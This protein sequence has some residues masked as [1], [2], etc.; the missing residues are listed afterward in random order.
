MADRTA[1][2]NVLGRQGPAAGTPDRG[3]RRPLEA[4]GT[5]R[6]RQQG[7]TGRSRCAATG[8]VPLR[9]RWVALVLLV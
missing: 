2:P 9:I 7:P 4:P 6:S 1:R 5:F 8:Q 3:F